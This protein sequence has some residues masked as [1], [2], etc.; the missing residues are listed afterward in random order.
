VEQGALVEAVGVL[1]D[2]VLVTAVVVGR[3][4]IQGLGVEEVT[5]IT[6]APEAV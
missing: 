6:H 1:S 2:A 3:A 5:G 4:G